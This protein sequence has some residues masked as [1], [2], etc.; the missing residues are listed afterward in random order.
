M[1]GNRAIYRVTLASHTDTAELHNDRTRLN[2]AAAGCFIAD[3][4]YVFM[5]YPYSKNIHLLKRE[6]IRHTREQFDS[7]SRSLFSTPIIKLI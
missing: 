2:R 3:T 7:L 4:N 5:P 1:T 6:L